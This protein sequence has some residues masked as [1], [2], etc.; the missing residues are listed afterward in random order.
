ML[1]PILGTRKRV[2]FFITKKAG[3]KNE[4][5]NNCLQITESPADARA[6]NINQSD[7]GVFPKSW[8]ND[9]EIYCH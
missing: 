5:K 3:R 6:K 4:Y 1:P 2:S 7:T 9:N 8:E